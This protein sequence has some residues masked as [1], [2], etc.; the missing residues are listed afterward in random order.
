MWILYAISNVTYAVIIV[1]CARL[2]YKRKNREY[3]KPQKVLAMVYFGS[4]LVSTF[5]DPVNTLID[6]AIGDIREYFL[7]NSVF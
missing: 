7:V 4:L 1:L 3:K 6:L 2:A 5:L